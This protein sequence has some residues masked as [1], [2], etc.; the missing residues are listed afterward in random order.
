MR[1]LT[2]IM[3]TLFIT[4]IAKTTFVA[5]S[6]EKVINKSEEKVDTSDL[7]DVEKTIIIVKDILSSISRKIDEQFDNMLIDVIDGTYKSEGYLIPVQEEMLKLMNYKDKLTPSV[8]ARIKRAQERALRRKDEEWVKSAQSALDDINQV[9]LEIEKYKRYIGEDGKIT[10]TNDI[11]QPKADEIISKIKGKTVL[12]KYLELYEDKLEYFLTGFAKEI[13]PDIKEGKKPFCITTYKIVIRDALM[14]I[15]KMDTY[16]VEKD[17]REAVARFPKKD[18]LA[19]L[20]SYILLI[21]KSNPNSV[22]MGFHYLK[23]SFD[24]LETEILAYNL[25]RVGL[26]IGR[27]NEGQILKIIDHVRHRKDMET[28]AK[29]SNMLLYFFIRND[30]YSKA[31]DYIKDL[32]SLHFDLSKI[33]PVIKFILFLKQGKY[34]KIAT[35]VAPYDKKR[36]VEELITS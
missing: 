14:K 8:E 3:I 9:M 13:Y 7:E 30:D 4:L 12:L 23:Q 28:L 34:E 29:L 16:S 2:T 25:V 1:L 27:I 6:A 31:F 32:K 21:N 22:D 15:N 19:L 35:D 10:L 36:Q 24:R 18:S 11:F 5:G 26:R 20:Y 33:S 17:L